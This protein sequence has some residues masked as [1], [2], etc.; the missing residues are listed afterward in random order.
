M[1]FLF[2]V[3]VISYS[4]HDYDTSISMFSFNNYTKIVLSI[5]NM[6]FKALHDADPSDPSVLVL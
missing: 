2:I 4:I 6:V 3:L 5:T 1:L